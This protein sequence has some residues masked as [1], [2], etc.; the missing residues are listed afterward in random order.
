MS[1]S[2]PS[3]RTVFN[4]KDESAYIQ[5][6]QSGIA[7]EGVRWMPLSYSSY[8]N[9]GTFFLRLASDSK[10]FKHDHLRGEEFLVL[11]GK[12]RDQVGREY[13]R[14]DFVALTPATPL[15]SNCEDGA[16]LLCVIRA[17]KDAPA[18][19]ATLSNPSIFCQ[20]AHNFES[21]VQFLAYGAPYP[22]V[23]WL[24]LTMDGTGAGS[25][26]ASYQPPARSMP[27]E[28]QG[29]EE[30]LIFEG[31]FRD[32][33]GTKF[34][35]GDFIVYPPGTRHSSYASESTLLFVSMGSPNKRLGPEEAKP[36]ESPTS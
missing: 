15:I 26:F 6:E 34:D 27:H 24:P 10:S 3:T 21:Y 31:S 33:D 5:Y 23:T 36:F 13:S 28:H 17:K 14:G 12:I 9:E 4:F 35:E 7:K 19:S 1:N 11:E 20:N 18:K 8:R 22:N 25:Y 32:F 30:F 2:Q 29:Y 16:T